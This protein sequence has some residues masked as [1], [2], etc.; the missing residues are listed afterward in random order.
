[1]IFYEL[2]DLQS[3]NLIGTYSTEAEALA[4]VS[5]VVALSGGPY[6]EDLALG[7]ADD[8]DETPGGQ[9]A[10]GAALIERAG[11]QRVA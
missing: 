9:I 7:W 5:S 1:M 11:S 6:A 2:W 10:T 4:V 3:R 8:Q